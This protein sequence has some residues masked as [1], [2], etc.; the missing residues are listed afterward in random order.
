MSEHQGTAV[1][2]N[3]ITLSREYGSGGGEI[4]ARLARRLAWRL[5]DHELV[6]RVARQL[7]VPAAAARA[8][9][10]QADV[11]LL[12]RFL[13]TLS[14]LEAGGLLDAGA[15]EGAVVE[16]A[17]DPRAY[18]ATL[19]R[20]VE[21][22]AGAGQVVIVG[23]GAQVL[24]AARRDTLH[25]RVVAPLAQRIAYVAQREGLDAAAA[26]RRI[27]AKERAR[28]RYLQAHYRRRPDDA[29]L[30]DLIVN[31][32]VLA[33]DSAVDLIALALE[34][35]GRQLAVPAAE[36]GPAAGLGRYPA[37]PVDFPTGPEGQ[38][39]PEDRG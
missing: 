17:V 31:T 37:R 27:Q 15:Q 36:L 21:A 13:R 38:P 3:V 12:A 34:H 24:L 22:T 2:M 5:I 35:K 26:Q 11:G 39:H 19:R 4:A 20:V 33:L 9:D 23:R 32:G 7:G 16:E 18:H 14:P 8:Y 29:H 1:A 30:Y 25:V 6:V 10:E 28:E